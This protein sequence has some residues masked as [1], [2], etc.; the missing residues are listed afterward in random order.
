[1]RILTLFFVSLLWNVSLTSQATCAT[2]LTLTPGTQQ[3]GDSSGNPGDFPSDNSAPNNPCST[4]HNDD[5]YWFTYT[6]APETDEIELTLSSISTFF[7]GIF[8]FDDC[9]VNGPN[10]IEHDVNLA[11]NSDITI[12]FPVSSTTTYKIAVITFGPPDGTTFCLDAVETICLNPVVS[13]LSDPY[14]F[15]NCPATLD[16]SFQI[17]DLT[18][19]AYS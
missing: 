9:P 4:N 7:T 18:D 14:D 3:C 17:D 11:S 5:E 1:M 15:T 12:S 19:S 2:A 13:T 6:P 10:C 16:Y 8:V